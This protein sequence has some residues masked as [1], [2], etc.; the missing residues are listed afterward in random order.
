MIAKKITDFAVFKSKHSETSSSS[1][2]RPISVT[3]PSDQDI[4]QKKANI[5]STGRMEGTDEINAP[6]SQL[7]AGLKDLLTPLIE[8]VHSL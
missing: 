5:E 6:S 3:S 8:E 2:K 4:K 1:K 7:I